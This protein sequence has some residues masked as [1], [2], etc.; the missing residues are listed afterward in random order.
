MGMARLVGRSLWIFVY[1]DRSR[2]TWSPGGFGEGVFVF[3][4]GVWGISCVKVGM[5]SQTCYDLYHLGIINPF[6]RGGRQ[7]RTMSTTIAQTPRNHTVHAETITGRERWGEPASV[8]HGSIRLPTLRP[9]ASQ[10]S[11]LPL[12]P[13]PVGSV[14]SSLAVA[15]RTPRRELQ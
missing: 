9:R 3:V 10:R 13:S 4:V 8:H 11:P 5:R 6:P 15:M 1:S 7:I 12:L 2:V 14:L